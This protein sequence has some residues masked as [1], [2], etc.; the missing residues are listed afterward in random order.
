MPRVQGNAPGILPSRSISRGSRI[1]TITTP[2]SPASLMASV[3]L[4]VSISAL[5]SSSNDLM[6]VWMVWGIFVTS[7][8]SRLPSRVPDAVQRPSRC[9]AEPGPTA[10]PILIGPGSAA[11]HSR[12]A[13]RPGHVFPLPHQLPHRAFQ[14]L[15]RDRVHAVGKQP[16][17]DGGRFRIVPVLLRHRIEPYRVRIGARDA[18]E[19]NRAGLFVDMLDRSA[20]HH[21][22]VR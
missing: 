14:A 20:R 7:C 13:L 18:I 16:A 9:I 11:H 17:D 8:A 22:L 5:A 1:S 10:R 6:P 21:D 12:A 2:S 19:P 4:T 3:A 15:D